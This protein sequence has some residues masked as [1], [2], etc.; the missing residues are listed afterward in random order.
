M[1]GAWVISLARKRR[2]ILIR[3]ALCG[4]GGSCRRVWESF[5]LRSYIS[6]PG[7]R[8]QRVFVHSASIDGGF[9]RN[10][11]GSDA[12]APDGNGLGLQEDLEVQFQRADG[13]TTLV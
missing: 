5:L 2:G 11:L 8:G 10:L 4:S 6:A 13:E 9:R 3:V 12:R 7:F 1:D